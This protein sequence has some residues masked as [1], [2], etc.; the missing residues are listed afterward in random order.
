KSKR[1]LLLLFGTFGALF[2]TVSG[3]AA[4]GLLDPALKS[5]A[6][7]ATKTQLPVFG[8]LPEN[9]EMPAEQKLLFTKAEN[10][11]ARQL[12]LRMQQKQAAQEPYVVG[13]LSSHMAEGKSTVVASLSTRLAASGLRTLTL[14]PN[15]HKQQLAVD[16][17][18]AFYSPLQGV[19]PKATLSDIAGASLAQYEVVIVEFPALL[20]AAYPAALLQRL[21]RV[22]TGF[23]FVGLV[24]LLL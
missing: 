7:A 3:I 22:Q 4:A 20:E 5:P 11:L 1:L 23:L 8:I 2:I 17:T 24:L 13:V 12:L 16:G 10:Q 18:V 21:V 14:L 15:D 9:R 19:S 6:L